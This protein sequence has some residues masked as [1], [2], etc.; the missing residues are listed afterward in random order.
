MVV[1]ISVVS[2]LHAGNF[3]SALG[4][5]R[6]LQVALGKLGF[7]SPDAEPRRFRRVVIASVIEFCLPGE[8]AVLFGCI[9]SAQTVI[10]KQRF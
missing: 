10:T 1:I 3:H 9:S 5:R 7:C 6:I 4:C 8:T 2:L